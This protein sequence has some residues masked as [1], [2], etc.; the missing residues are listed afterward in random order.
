MAPGPQRNEVARAFA[1]AAASYAR[2]DFL[3][4][5]VRARLLERL[6]CVSLAPDTVIDLGAGPPEATL[7]L[8]HRYPDA[9]L[10]AFDL[11]PAMLGAAPQPWARLAGDAARM[12]L[13]DDTADLVVAGMLLHWCTDAQAV[14][15]EVRRVLRYPGLFTFSTLGP[16]TLRELRAAW[17]QVDEASHTL[18]FTDMHDI[19]D[20]LLRAG[21]AEPV[22]E[23]EMLTVTYADTGRMIADVRDV[24]SADLGPRR[25]RTLTG[26][27]RWRAMT[28]AYEALRSPEGTLPV[29]IEIVYGHAWSDDPSR[30]GAADRREIAVPLERL[31]RR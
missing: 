1:R 22:L 11:V 16:D 19:G 21:F 27:R 8:A 28:A 2:A 24:G 25:R 10:I 26:R 5:E 7:A 17:A 20:A 29:T 9:R 15:A 30:R 12:P 14:F 3:H 31:R 23:A 4:A 6:A 18:Q 13:A